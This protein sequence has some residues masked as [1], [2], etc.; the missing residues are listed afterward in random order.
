MEP[1]RIVPSSLAAPITDCYYSCLNY[2]EEHS[3]R[4]NLASL[5]LDDAA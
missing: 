4:D 1:F 5:K 3:D 2:P